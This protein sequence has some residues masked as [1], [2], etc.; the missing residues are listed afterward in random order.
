MSYDIRIDSDTKRP[1]YNR[2]TCIWWQQ[3]VLVSFL[4][5]FLWYFQFVYNEDSYPFI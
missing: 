5:R 4:M 3:Q 1:H 2:A